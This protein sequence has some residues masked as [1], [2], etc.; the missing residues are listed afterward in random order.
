[1]YLLPFEVFQADFTNNIE[2]SFFTLKTRM[3]CIGHPSCWWILRS[4]RTLMRLRG[5][6]ETV[7][8]TT[9]ASSSRWVLHTTVTTNTTNTTNTTSSITTF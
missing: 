8:T 3:V 9:T 1:M 4:S 2:F 7:N 6:Q 5:S